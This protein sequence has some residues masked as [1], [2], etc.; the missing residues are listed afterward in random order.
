MSTFGYGGTR[1]GMLGTWWAMLSDEYGGAL[2]RGFRFANEVGVTCGP[3]HFLVGV[4]EGDGPAAR[5]L[6][7][8]GRSLR[9][10]VTTEPERYAT[11]A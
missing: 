9:D 1:G 11:V 6:S 8:S 10:V 3:V 4:A 7:G 2:L 5:A